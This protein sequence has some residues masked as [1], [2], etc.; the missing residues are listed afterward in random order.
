M[1]F[2]YWHQ[3]AGVLLQTHSDPILEPETPHSLPHHPSTRR[4]GPTHTP[5]NTSNACPFHLPSPPDRTSLAADARRPPIDAFPSPLLPL[6]WSAHSLSVSFDAQSSR[7]LHPHATTAPIPSHRPP[8][9]E[10][11]TPTSTQ[12]RRIRPAYTLLPLRVTTSITYAH[13]LAYK[14]IPTH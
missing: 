1:S 3:P 11:H 4:P 12:S 2:L 8:S 5:S 7:P 9:N 13:R 10:N 6:P 14:T